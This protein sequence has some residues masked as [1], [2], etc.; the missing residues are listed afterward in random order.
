M[1]TYGSCPDCGIHLGH[2]KGCKRAEPWP[3][4]PAAE[5]PMKPTQSGTSEREDERQE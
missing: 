1:T 3:S 4:I 2:V 5:R